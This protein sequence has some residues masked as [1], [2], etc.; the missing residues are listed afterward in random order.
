MNVCGI[1]A[2]LDAE[3][4]KE[5]A[6][7]AEVDSDAKLIVANDDGEI[8]VS[9]VRVNEATAKVDALGVIKDVSVEDTR[10]VTVTDAVIVTDALPGLVPVAVAKDADGVLVWIAD[11]VTTSDAVG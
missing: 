6:G 7:E 8:V 5:A 3:C 10:A 11:T 4:V 1:V 9:I 2:A